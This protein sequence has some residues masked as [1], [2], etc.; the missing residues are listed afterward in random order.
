MADFERERLERIAAN[1]KKVQELGLRELSEA[2]GGSQPDKKERKPRPAKAE[3]T[4][5]VERRLSV[6]EK[7]KVSYKEDDYWGDL[8]RAVRGPA[9]VARTFDPDEVEALR[10]KNGRAAADGGEEAGEEGG[11]AG[12]DAKKRGPQDSGKGV[13]IQG[14]KV[15]DST[16][17][18]TCHW[19]RQK[20]LEDHVICSHPGCGKGKRMPTTFC[21]NCLK[22][23]HGEDCEAAY[24]S[25]AWVCPGCRGSCG[26]G[27]VMC[28][29][30]GP[31]RKKAG[32]EPTHQVL[33]NARDVGFDNVHD[34][35]VHLVTGESKE[36]VTARKHKFAWAKWMKAGAGPAA[37]GAAEA[38]QGS[39]P[40][41]AAAASSA[42]AA[43]TSGRGA[44]ASSRAAPAPAAGAGGA[45]AV[46]IEE[47]REVAAA[48][49]SK[50]KRPAGAPPKP[51]SG[52]QA[53]KRAKGP[54]EAEAEPA[55]QQQQAKAATA[56]AAATAL[57][58]AES[59]GGGRGRG[60]ARAGAPPTP[61]RTDLKS[62]GSVP[63][64]GPQAGGDDTAAACRVLLK[65]PIDEAESGEGAPGDAL[66]GGAPGAKLS[67]KQRML[68]KLGLGASQPQPGSLVV[69]AA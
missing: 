23:R 53:A 46:A 47:D 9:R 49:P 35:L 30:C 32:L 69:E 52:W 65:D 37:G 60:G 2:A 33:K 40:E 38:D 28:C 20:T 48:G 22:N 45:G 13:R 68:A 27:C 6:R 21:K 14:G 63:C 1:R 36:E 34:Y 24:L 44:R 25:G 42:A 5:S 51:P 10:E 29:N 11:D 19:C 31:C 18:V 59:A 67:R 16:F 61:P 54:S 39:R 50:P 66:A 64:P 62:M 41:A 15:Y 12:D 17:G 57:P 7:P 58:E 43:G 8:P 55:Q 56:S 26:R 4:E 3:P